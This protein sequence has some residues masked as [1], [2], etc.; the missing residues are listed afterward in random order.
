MKAMDPIMRPGSKVVPVVLSMVFQ[1]TVNGVPFRFIP[2]ASH[3]KNAIDVSNFRNRQQQH[4]TLV[5]R[6]I[7][8]LVFLF[9]RL[10]TVE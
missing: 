6:M 7:A 1:F 8:S 10:C 3:I 5:Y 4:T 9:F 2:E